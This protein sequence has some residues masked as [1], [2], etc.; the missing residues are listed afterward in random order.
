MTKIKNLV[1]QK[2]GKLLVINPTDKRNSKREVIWE[3]KC[4]C[5]NKTFANTYSL[6]SGHTK[7]CG[8]SINHESLSAAGKKGGGIVKHNLS[9]TRIYKT[10]TDMIHRCHNPNNPEFKN[11]GSRGIKVCDEW[12]DKENGVM[13]F[14]NWAINNGYKENLSIDRI[15][16]NGN[17]CP[18]NCRWATNKE[19][20]NNKRNNCFLEY[21]GKILTI[22]QWSEILNIKASYIYKKNR[23]NWNLDKIIERYKI[24]KEKNNG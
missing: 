9:K 16:V 7:S 2:F 3:C 23:Q 17:Y 12:L 6:T 11:Y 13:S 5:G 24:L 19:Q 15:D 4:D 14:Y 8:C 21:N 10:Y 20:Q 22:A 1:G 18:E